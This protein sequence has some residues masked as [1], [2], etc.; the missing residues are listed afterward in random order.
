MFKT[1]GRIVSKSIIKEGI[2][3]HG[4]WK[5][6]WFAIERT[7]CKKKIRFAFTVFGTKAE[8]V[9]QIIDKERI[10]VEFLPECKYN[11]KAK[12]Y[13]TE[14]KVIDVYKYVKKKRTDIWVDNQRLN[15]SDYNI[16]TEQQLPFRDEML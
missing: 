15:E 14:L 12:R 7:Y 8:F 6:M 2:S 1:N 4:K 13:F 11:E 10:T 9:E 5:L 3:Q 16:N